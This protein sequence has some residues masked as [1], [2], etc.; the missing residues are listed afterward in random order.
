VIVPT[1]PLADAEPVTASDHA[2]SRTTRVLGEGFQLFIVHLLSQARV[3]SR[4]GVPDA[5]ERERRRER[6]L[7]VEC[8]TPL[9]GWGLDCAIETMDGCLTGSSGA[10]ILARTSIVLRKEGVCAGGSLLWPRFS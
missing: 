1:V 10:D 5:P 8:R 3:C 9:Y 6:L 7:E 2:R 4:P